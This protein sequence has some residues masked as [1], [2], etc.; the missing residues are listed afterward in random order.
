MKMEATMIPTKKIPHVEV[1]I[2]HKGS[3]KESILSF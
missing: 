3:N 2:T 1:M